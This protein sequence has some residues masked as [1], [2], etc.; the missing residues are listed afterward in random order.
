L[1]VT[2]PVGDLLFRR[3]RA[4][5]LALPSGALWFKPAFSST[6]GDAVGAVSFSRHRQP[7]QYCT[8]ETLALQDRFH[9][10]A[11][12]NRRS[13]EA[14]TSGDSPGQPPQSRS[15]SLDIIR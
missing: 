3:F 11:Q 6:A 5:A 1:T 9:T 14:L 7:R 13:G 2:L 4:P 8:R 12:R 15:D 10:P